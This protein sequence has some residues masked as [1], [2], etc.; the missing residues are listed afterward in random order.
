[1]S[2]LPPL[3]SPWST[4][5]MRAAMAHKLCRPPECGGS[6]RP[7]APLVVPPQLNKRVI[8]IMLA[9]LVELNIDYLRE[10]PN[11]PPIF[12]SGIRYEAE[13]AGQEQWL[14]IPFVLMRRDMGLGADCEDLACWRVAELRLRLGENAHPIVTDRSMPD[15]SRVYHIRVKRGKRG[16]GGAVMIE[17]PSAILG[18]N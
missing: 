1:M 12:S 5:A 13:P 6:L 18:M 4:P 9:A 7:W 14:S 17:D 15:G 10:H 8:E 11:T 2:F 16:K 3:G